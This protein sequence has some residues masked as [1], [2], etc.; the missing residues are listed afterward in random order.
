MGLESDLTTNMQSGLSDV[1]ATGPRFEPAGG[2]SAERTRCV[3]EALGIGGGY[4]ELCDAKGKVIDK[5]Q[6]RH[7]D[8]DV[9]AVAPLSP[10]SA[11]LVRSHVTGRCPYCAGEGVVTVFD[12]SL[13]IG[14]PKAKPTDEKFLHTEAL[15]ILRGVRK[16][17]LLPFLKRMSVEGLWPEGKSF[18]SLGAEEHSILMHGYWHRPGPGSFLKAPKAN[19]EEVGSWLRWD[20]LFRVTF[21]ELD[22]STSKGWVKDIQST[23]RNN[24]CPVCEGTGMRPHVR[25]IKLGTKSFFDL[26]KVG[27][28]GDLVK[29]LET[30]A[31]ASERSKRMRKRILHCLEPLSRSAHSAKLRESFDDTKLL[32]AVFERTVH[33]LTRLEV[34][35]GEA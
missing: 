27:S 13:V 5:I 31:P 17:V 24:K 9:P 25:A 34:L 18:A 33:S 1:R 35:K 10:S 2:T 11:F 32:R 6:R 3:R 26:V 16:S 22:R 8:L 28:V 21:E 15:K 7:L 4:V 20:G 30:L 14:Q 29:A 23:K 12:E 19:P